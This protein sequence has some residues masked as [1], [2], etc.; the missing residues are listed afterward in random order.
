MTK[1][2]N[3]TPEMTASIV[4]RYLAVREADEATRA[5]VFSEL[6]AEFGKNE[7]SI[8]AKLSREQINGESVYVPKVTVSKV[9]GEAAAKK[10]DMA[11]HLVT[12]FSV[13]ADPENVA[14]MNKLDIQA[15]I[16]RFEEITA[17]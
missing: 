10:V 1:T 17:G 12:E 13:N 4:D 9:T 3:Y 5:R 14:K 11:N 2:V 16:D 7:R 8:R 15:F 6:A